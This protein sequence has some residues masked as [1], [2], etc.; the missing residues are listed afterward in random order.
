MLLSFA[1]FSGEI[2]VMDLCVYITGNTFFRHVWA[3]TEIYTSPQSLVCNYK[4][5]TT[6]KS[7]HSLVTFLGSS[8]ALNW[9]ETIIII[10]LIQ[11]S[12]NIYLFHCPKQKAFVYTVLPSPSW[13][14]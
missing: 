13:K 2:R 5:S 14:R 1:F 4:I 9:S 3:Q 8:L 6:L 10:L 11:L 7:I 12:M